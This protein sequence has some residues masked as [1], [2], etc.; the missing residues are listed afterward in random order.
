[1]RPWGR[2]LEG[3]PNT[4]AR[5]AGWR[6]VTQ[7]GVISYV[8][9]GPCRLS[10]SLAPVG[11]W[12]ITKCTRNTVMSYV[13]Q[14]STYTKV[15]VLWTHTEIWTPVLVYEIFTL[16]Y[17]YISSHSDIFSIGH[18]KWRQ[19]TKEQLFYWWRE[20]GMNS[21]KGGHRDEK[22]DSVSTWLDIC[23]AYLLTFLM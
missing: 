1:M 12:S 11:V 18:I 21:G 20:D 22:Y 8:M 23:S 14:R 2:R 16:S 6:S 3:W 19:K 5:L 4:A 13:K 15:L 9:D 7:Q 10:W 17:P